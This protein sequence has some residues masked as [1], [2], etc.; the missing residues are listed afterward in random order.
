MYED[1]IHRYIAVDGRYIP[2][3]AS[4]LTLNVMK[5][6]KDIMQLLQ[7]FTNGISFTIFYDV[8]SQLFSPTLV[9]MAVFSLRNK[10]AI[11]IDPQENRVFILRKGCPASEN[12]E[13]KCSS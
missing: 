10:Q 6:E 5:I 2:Y 7:P 8:V 11:V 12:Y 13:E 4:D 9:Y 3:N 1:S